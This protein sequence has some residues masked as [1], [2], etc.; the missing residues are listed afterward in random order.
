VNSCVADEITQANLIRR[1]MLKRFVWLF[2]ATVF[3]AFQIVVNSALAVE[4]DAN[5]RTVKLNEQ[6]ENITLN[7][8]QV[9][10]GK[11]LFNAVC[12]QCHA[13]GITKTDFNVS[14]SPK[15][16][17]GATPARDNVD[18]LVDYLHHPTTY[19]GETLISEVHPSTDSADIFPE[20]RN[21]SEDDLVALAG[22]ILIQPKV[23]GDQWGGGKAVR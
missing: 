23:L 16:L 14:L 5:T 8:K 19:D 20:M 3:F 22:H 10:E 11:R 2:V 13:G 15:D 7:L 1:T 17:S 9:K 21:L 4:L 12:A 18:A 6:G